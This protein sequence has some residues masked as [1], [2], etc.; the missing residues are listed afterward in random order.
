M[1]YKRKLLIKYSL[2][3]VVIVVG[4]SV[5]FWIDEWNRN[6]IEQ[7]QHVK[8]IE[9]IIDDLDNDS[10][11]IN[12]VNQSLDT[13]RLRTDR[14]INL[15]ELKLDNKIG[16]NS[17]Y[18]K[19]IN[20]GY[21]WSYQTFFMTDATY[22][23]LISNGRINLYPQN[24]HSMT[25]KYYEA[26]AKR[27]HDHNKIVDDIA[28]KYYTYYH[29]FS[30]LFTNENFRNN[31]FPDVRLGVNGRRLNFSSESLKKFD[32]YFK[33]NDIKKLYTEIDFYSNTI[34]MNN[35]VGNYT[36]RIFELETERL[37]LSKSI[38]NYLK[39]LVKN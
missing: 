30:M 33:N 18:K 9:S 17:Y 5:T 19:I 13:G 4:I 28:I 22:K 8:D 15:I 32:N 14:L 29:P 39:T 10:L 2:E 16:Y 6:R 27:I 37:K 3:F 7:I 11:I 25:N 34:N 31:L 21:L 12:R 20:I 23:S 38:H 36:R 24:I 26:T 1:D 35:R